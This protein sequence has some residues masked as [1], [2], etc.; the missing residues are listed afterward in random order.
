MILT[1]PEIDAQ[2]KTK[3]IIIEPYDPSN[4]NPNSYNFALGDKLLVYQNKVLDPHQDNPTEERI[5]PE[6]G[7][8]LKPSRLYLAYIE[9][10]IGS[11]HYVPI[12][13]GRSSIGRLGLF[14]TITADLVDQGAVGQWTLMMHCVQP[15][16]IYPHMRI[17]QMTFWKP[18]GE[19]DLYHGKYQHAEGPR[20]SESFQDL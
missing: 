12:I 13:K 5:I 17:G 6:E 2:V 10:R 8:K 11:A 9:E 16:I 18:T 14:I 7:L 20:P 1:G 4:L 15:I 3:R 19:P